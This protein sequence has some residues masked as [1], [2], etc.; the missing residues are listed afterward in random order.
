MTLDAMLHTSSLCL[1]PI[2]R[3]LFPALKFNFTVGNTFDS[4]PPSPVTMNFRRVLRVAQSILR[5]DT[6][7]GDQTVLCCPSNVCTVDL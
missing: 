1:L 2:A 5:E 6:P 3:G 4:L 7:E